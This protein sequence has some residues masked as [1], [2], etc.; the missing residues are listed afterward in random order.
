MKF[1]FDLN[2]RSVKWVPRKFVDG[3]LGKM[4]TLDNPVFVLTPLGNPANDLSEWGLICELPGYRGQYRR[5]T[6]KELQKVADDL[7]W[8]WF[9]SATMGEADASQS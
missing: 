5:G 3:M 1:T 7:L 2:E 9:K 4:G 6:K 8:A